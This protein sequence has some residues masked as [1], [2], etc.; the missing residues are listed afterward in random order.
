M[1]TGIVCASHKFGKCIAHRGKV[2]HWSDDMV[3]G[4]RYNLIIWCKAVPLTFFQPLPFKFPNDMPISSDTKRVIASYLDVKT[5]NRFALACKEHVAIARDQD[6]WFRLCAIE[7]GKVANPTQHVTIKTEKAISLLISNT[8]DPQVNWFNAH[9]TV[10]RFAYDAYR[11]EN[12]PVR[13]M[14]SVRNS[15]NST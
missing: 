8:F 2:Q 12:K 9:N 4:S 6:L 5:L 1:E 11:T 13:R 3:K 7:F 14:K 15:I 10:L